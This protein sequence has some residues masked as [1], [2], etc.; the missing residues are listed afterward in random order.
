MTRFS[1]ASTTFHAS[2]AA[3]AALLAIC[4]APAPAAAQLI[5]G[6]SGT[7]AEPQ[8][9]AGATATGSG[10]NLACGLS[11]SADGT[12]SHNTATG[13]NANASGNNAGNTA[14]G[15][16][17]R[18]FG[19]GSSNIANGLVA[20]ASGANSSNIAIGSSSGDLTVLGAHAEGDNSRNIAI[21]QNANATGNGTNNVAIGANTVATGANATALGNGAQATFA[22]STAIGNGAVA[23]R[24]NQQAFGTASN[25]Y[26]MAGITS[27][28]STAAQSGPLSIVTSDPNGN[29]ATSSLAGLGFA[30]AAE[31]AAIN[32][33][34][35]GLNTRIDDLTRESRR[36]IAATAALAT[37]MTPSAPG[38]TTVSLNT[39]FFQ[40][41]TGLGVAL[42][43]RLNFTIPL[44][45]HGSYA[46]AGGN[47]HVGRV[48]LAFE[49]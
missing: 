42:A 32:T 4:L 44:I 13:T 43:H 20:T 7:G 22:N 17:A 24:A 41:E 8:G 14:Y 47:G 6:V 1:L 46:N 34:L 28:A 45:V 9:G 36:G 23:T 5:C 15:R 10:N 2:F 16:S 30:S 31:I 27:A 33:Q 37:A 18:A 21:G 35:A 3:F 26:T 19:E 39:G 40:G 11:A 12:S 38:K 29:L 48:G 49:F 25:T